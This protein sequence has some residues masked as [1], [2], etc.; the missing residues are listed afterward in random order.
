MICLIA[1]CLK[2]FKAAVKKVLTHDALGGLGCISLLLVFFTNNIP[3]L[4]G[5]QLLEAKCNETNHAS[6]KLLEKLG[7][8]TEAKLR[9]RR[10]DLMTGERSAL[11]IAS[12][13]RGEAI[14]FLNKDS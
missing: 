4:A 12:I 7:F 5:F 13:T 10:M 8:L 1:F 11:V 3:Q 14:H 9:G 6:R 2:K